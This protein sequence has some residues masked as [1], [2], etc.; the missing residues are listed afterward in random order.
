MDGKKISLWGS[1]P[2]SS[3]VALPHQVSP[4][5]NVNLINIKPFFVSMSE[6][7]LWQVLLF[8]G[9][10]KVVDIARFQLS[11][12]TLSLLCHRDK[13]QRNYSGQSQCKDFDQL[14]Q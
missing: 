5:R 10:I 6:Y 2:R 1:K 8:Y 14:I 4:H 9:D 11:A 12:A 3:A 7:L 13:N